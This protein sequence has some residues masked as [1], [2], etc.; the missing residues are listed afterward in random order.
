M[1]GNIIELSYSCF[2]DSSAFL[3]WYED[4]NN[5]NC[6]YTSGGQVVSFWT[7]ENARQ[8]AEKLGITVTDTCFFD[9]ERLVYWIEMHQNEIDCDFLIDFWNIF[10]DI[11]YSVGKELEPVRTKCSDKCFNKLFWGLNLPV[12]T[13]ENCE[14]EPVFTKRERKLIREIICTG[15]EIFEKNSEWEE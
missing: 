13:P 5:E 3:I 10:S 2:G 4:E 15:L 1:K 9:V 7:E 8:K 12:V 14:Y 6:I 11:A